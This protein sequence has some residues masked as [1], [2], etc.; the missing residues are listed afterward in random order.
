MEDVIIKLAQVESVDDEADGLRI[1]ARLQQDGTKSVDKLPYAF[2]LLPKT[3]QSIPKVG[4]CV[5]ILT[6]KMGNNESNRYYIGPIISQP[7][8]QE[9]DEYSYGRGTASS[10][11]QG[12]VVKPLEKISN[13]DD[14]VGAFPE[15]KDVAL[16]GRNTEDITIK[17][18]EIDVRCGIRGTAAGNKS[19][20][21]E[22]VFN[23]QSPSYLQLKYKKGLLSLNNE[24]I[25]SVINVVAD[26]INLISHKD[27]NA[28]N[29]TDNRE[30]IKNSQLADIMDKLHQVPYGDVLI[31]A[32]NK[33]I[34][35]ITNHVHPY[36]GLPACR[37]QYITSTLGINLNEI[38]S[39]NVR[40]S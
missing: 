30:L 22:V 37:D 23:K 34:L 12:G 9:Y 3:F 16:I 5:L 28:F 13:Y 17:Q 32:L 1:K 19:L 7:Q 10:L 14:T 11:L 21:G 8:Y 39:N 38:L 40:I 20:L 31:D 2:P 4:E 36:P 25:D 29:L 6:S 33:I 24:E 18:G 15:K 27:P 26:K 35:A